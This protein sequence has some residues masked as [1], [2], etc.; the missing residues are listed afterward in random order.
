MC[1]GYSVFAVVQADPTATLALTRI[2]ADDVAATLPEPSSSRGSIPHLSTVRTPV[3]NSASASGAAGSGHFAAIEG[4]EDEDMELQAALQASLGGGGD[5][6]FVLPPRIPPQVPM[7]P[8]RGFPTRSYDLPSPSEIEFPNTVHTPMPD[9]PSPE[10]SPVEDV[11]SLDPV[12]RSMARNKLI[13]E[14]MRRE[15]EMALREQYEAEVAA[16]PAGSTGSR[17]RAPRQ[18]EDDEDEMLR[19]AIAESE[20]LARENAENDDEAIDEDDSDDDDEYVSPLGSPPLAPIPVRTPLPDT[21]A[22]QPAYMSHRVYDDDDAELQAALKASLEHMPEGFV[23]PEVPP[24]PSLPLPRPAPPASGSSTAPP[25]R[26]AE[27]LSSDT[28]TSMSAGTEME[29]EQPEEK[30][31]VDEM[32]R[33][34][35]ARFGG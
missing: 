13:M 30:I 10:L 24:M 18:E 34:R 11:D 3:E 32:R 5:F 6:N 26:R 25:L 35:L 12:A 33:R 1:V 29:V 17:R 27:S 9:M 2:D 16:A 21:T 22:P 4:F 14:R 31:D 28:G 8:P 20:A 19:R 23:I 7:P 15:Q